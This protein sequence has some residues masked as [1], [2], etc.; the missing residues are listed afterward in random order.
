MSA[1][2]YVGEIILVGFNFAP[3]G[4]ALCNGQ[5][6]QISQNETLFQLIG[7]TYGGD[8]QTTFGLPDLRGRI[9][10]GTGQG[11]GLQNYFLGEMAGSESMTLTMQ[12]LA[13]HIHPIDTSG[14][15]GMLQCKNGLGNQQAPTGNVHAIEAA[16]ATMPYSSATPDG[17]MNANGASGAGTIVVSNVGGSVPHG[18]MQP[19]LALNFCISLFGYFPA[20]S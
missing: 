10:I 20:P 19:Y 17:T 16:G 14:M 8:G 5:L 9:P 7:T 1:D 6:L 2:P 11:P 4:W 18:N 15:S 12:Q 13:P 3:A